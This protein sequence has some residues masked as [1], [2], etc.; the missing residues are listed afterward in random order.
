MVPKLHILEPVNLSQ[1]ESKCL[2]LCNFSWSKKIIFFIQGLSKALLRGHFGYTMEFL[3]QCGTL[4][5][6]PVLGLSARFLNWE[7]LFICEPDT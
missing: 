6:V 2:R 1:F 3:S 4:L 5:F 7:S